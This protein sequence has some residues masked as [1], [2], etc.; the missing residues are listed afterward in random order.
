M[1]MKGKYGNCKD[2]NRAWRREPLIET[3]DESL[4]VMVFWLFVGI[5]C[6]FMQRNTLVQIEG[7]CRSK[8]FPP[9][10]EPHASLEALP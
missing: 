7:P 2:Q 3:L 1:R 9:H 6:V 8:T 10:Q 4:S 5:R